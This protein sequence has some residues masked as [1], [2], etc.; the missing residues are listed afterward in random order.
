[1][2]CCLPSSSRNKLELTASGATAK[3]KIKVSPLIDL[4]KA[5]GVDKQVFKDS[6]ASWQ[7]G[8][9]AKLLAVPTFLRARKNGKLRLAS[10]DMNLRRA[11]R[12]PLRDCSCLTLDGGGIYK[13]IRIFWNFPRCL[14]R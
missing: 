10:F 6:K 12:H 7:E 9:Q 11:V 14:G 4:D 5:G 3:Y 1:M 8:V 2:G 13:S